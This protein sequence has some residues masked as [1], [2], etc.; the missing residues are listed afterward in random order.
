MLKVTCRDG[1]SL[2]AT[3]NAL[4]LRERRMFLK[5]TPGASC[6]K[7]SNMVDYWSCWF[8]WLRF[9]NTA[10]LSQDCNNIVNIVYRPNSLFRC[11]WFLPISL[12]NPTHQS[13]HDSRPA[14]QKPDLDAGPSTEAADYKPCWPPKWVLQA[15]LDLDASKKCL[16]IAFH[17]PRKVY[18]KSSQPK[19]SLF[20]ATKAADSRNRPLCSAAEG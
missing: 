7:L 5:N 16:L 13:P 12:E 20:E 8:L 3:H 10:N 17:P 15:I 6:P 18:Y 14:E 19:K 9:S 11:P 1:P 2:A 4:T